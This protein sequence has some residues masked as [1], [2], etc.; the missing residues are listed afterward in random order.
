M[1]TME[2]DVEEFLALVQSSTL[3]ELIKQ[4]DLSFSV[5]GLVW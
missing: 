5:P 3:D 2:T 1:V 4:S